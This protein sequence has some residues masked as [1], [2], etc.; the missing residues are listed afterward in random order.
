MDKMPNH[1]VTRLQFFE[2]DPEW[3]GCTR[4]VE[5]PE[6]VAELHEWFEA[7]KN[8]CEALMPMPELFR[9]TGSGGC[10]LKD[11][12]GVEHHV[13]SWYQ[14]RETN[15]CRL[16]TEEEKQQLEKSGCSNWYDWALA[17]W[18]TKL[19]TYDSRWVEPHMLDFESAWGPP[20][21]KVFQ[22]LADELGVGFKVYGHDEGYEDFEFAAD[23]SFE[24]RRNQDG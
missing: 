16:F 4:N 23:G 1:W 24:P 5:T 9:N 18:G 14:D 10:K 6:V 7:N 19:G 20:E 11:K 8:I 2:P 12:D 13:N 21:D 22:L 17:N 15:E 3:K